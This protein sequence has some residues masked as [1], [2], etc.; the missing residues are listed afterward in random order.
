MD[1][2]SKQI[3]EE[4]VKA[5]LALSGHTDPEQARVW[6]EAVTAILTNTTEETVTQFPKKGQANFRQMI[7]MCRKSFD[8]EI[9]A[10]NKY[11]T[12]I[13][14]GIAPADAAS[15]MK[16]RLEHQ[17]QPVDFSGI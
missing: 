12:D 1:D 10:Y 17:R 11:R 14:K 7:A 5:R 16:T 3:I 8:L 15:R 9:A 4:S 6:C 13:R 2:L